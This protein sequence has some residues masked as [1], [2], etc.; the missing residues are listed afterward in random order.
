VT[1][2]RQGNINLIL[3]ADSHSF[4]R[5]YFLERGPTVCAIGLNTDDP[6]GR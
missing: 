6:I 5:T 4:A 1:L 3:N 2:Y